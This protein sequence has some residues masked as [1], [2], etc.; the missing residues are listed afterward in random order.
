MGILKKKQI[1]LICALLAGCMIATVFPAS[2]YAEEDEEEEQEEEKEDLSAIKDSIKEKEAEISKANKE[3]KDLMSGLN[4][5]KGIVNG[6]KA[7]K[8]D[9]EKYVV[10][11][12]ANLTEIEEEIA[13]LKDLIAEKEKEILQT[14]KELE[15]AV[16][17]EENQYQSMKKRVRFLYEK[18]DAYYVEMLFSAGSF[19]EF[20][21]RK[22]YIEKLS[23]YDK[24]MMDTY[25]ANRKLIEVCKKELEAD[26]EL[27]KEAKKKV[28][29]Q[30]KNVEILISDKEKEINKY[31]GDIS[32][33]Q[34][35]IAE[36]EA[37]IAVQNDVIQAL[38]AAL[39]E[40]RKQLAEEGGE[41]IAYDGGMF[42]WPCPNYTRISDDYGMRMHPILHVNKFHNG[43][44]LAAPSGSPILAAYDGEV[45]AADY[46]GSMGNYVMI[47]HGG[48]L[49]T[50]YMHASSLGVSKGDWVTKGQ[51]IAGVGTTGRSTGNHLHFG[52]RLNGQ[53]VSPW[54]Y[55]SK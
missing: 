17:K 34:K 54:N 53:Y 5:I 4:N 36:Y 49:I 13:R 38:E 43:I 9:L 22:D 23:D 51:K 37:S 12:D 11:L 18:G 50:I 33:Q 32:E 7:E 3:K 52:V 21:N 31:A 16:E 2:V 45:I 47:N 28:D 24:K 41:E 1:R 26:E 8:K 6:L 42:K 48:G 46:N 44:D 27:L 10:K 35:A 30:Q 20:I 29:E 19:G 25:V 15:N 40:Q 14:T 39:A 55:L